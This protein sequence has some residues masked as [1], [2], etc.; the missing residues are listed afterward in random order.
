MNNLNHKGFTLIELM[1]VVVIITL[2]MAIAIPSYQRYGRQNNENRARQAIEQI[3]LLLERHKARNFSYLGFADTP[4]APQGYQLVITDAQ[5]NALSGTTQSTGA[6]WS[7]IAINQTGDAR[8][9]SLLMTN[10]GVRCKNVTS[11]NITKTTCGAGGEV[12]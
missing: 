6:T 3:A 4:T 12:W 5:G 2:L 9:A 11:S 8:Q 7:L 1:V 10:N